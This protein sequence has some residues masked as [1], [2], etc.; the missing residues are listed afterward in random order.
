MSAQQ[1]QA[2]TSNSAFRISGSLCQAPAVAWRR[3]GSLC[4]LEQATEWLG[5]LRAASVH[6]QRGPLVPV[7]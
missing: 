6:E 5:G 3:R 4:D 1:R 2:Q 7:Y